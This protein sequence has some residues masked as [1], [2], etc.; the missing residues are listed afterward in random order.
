M[1]VATKMQFTQSSEDLATAL[2]S[3]LSSTAGE[4]QSI[5]VCTSVLIR[6]FCD[7]QERV[8]RVGSTEKSSNMMLLVL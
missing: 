1:M 6:L 5:I 3:V 2:M 8:P 7:L 4:Q